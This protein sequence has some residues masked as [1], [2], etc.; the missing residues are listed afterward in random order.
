MNEQGIFL[1]D[2]LF[3]SPL[4]IDALNERLVAY[5]EAYY[6]YCETN[7]ALTCKRPIA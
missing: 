5:G 1:S 6:H 2:I 7:N 3:S 4:D